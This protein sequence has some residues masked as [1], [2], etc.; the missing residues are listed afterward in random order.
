RGRPRAA[1]FRGGLVAYNAGAKG[2]GRRQS[3]REYPP[4]GLRTPQQYVHSLK[5]NRTVYFRGER[6]SDV[7]PHPVI[8][9]ALRRATSDY[10]MPCDAATRDL[11]VVREDGDEYSRYFKIPASNEDLLK[12]AQLIEEATARG[13]TLVVLVKEIGTDALFAL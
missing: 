10:E 4:T 11:A 5:D 3:I 9:M 7:P 2:I 8:K 6:G 12:R 1:Q 13:K